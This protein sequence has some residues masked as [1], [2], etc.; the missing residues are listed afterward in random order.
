[1]DFKLVIRQLSDARARDIYDTVVIDTV[2]EAYNACEKFICAQNG[3]QKIGD[4]PWGQGYAQ[5]KSEFESALRSITM[6][7]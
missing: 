6:L 1:M 4:I 5:T 7:G 2:S 3:V